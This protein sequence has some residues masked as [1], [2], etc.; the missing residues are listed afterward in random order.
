MGL[1]SGE[2]W[3]IIVWSVIWRLSGESPRRARPFG[4]V[5][6]VRLKEPAP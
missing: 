1:G 3:S 2:D 6:G 5:D 4:S